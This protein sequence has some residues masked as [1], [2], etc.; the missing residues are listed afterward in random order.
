VTS[1]FSETNFVARRLGL[2]MSNLHTKLEVFTITRNESF[3]MKCRQ[4][5]WWRGR[6]WVQG[7]WRAHDTDSKRH[8]PTRTLFQISIT[9]L[10]WV[11]LT[12]L[13]GWLEFNPINLLAGV[14]NQQN[15]LTPWIFRVSRGIGITYFQTQNT[16]I[17]T[18]QQI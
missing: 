18:F 8:L 1:P 5:R 3:Q 14:P 4:F 2:P 12:R 17:L 9:M 13:V 10:K 15:S 6:P 16:W 7:N 11:S